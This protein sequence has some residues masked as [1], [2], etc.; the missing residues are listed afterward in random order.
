MIALFQ[1][2]TSTPEYIFPDS[3]LYRKHTKGRYEQDWVG[4]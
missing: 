1:N 3:I 2:Q 4:E